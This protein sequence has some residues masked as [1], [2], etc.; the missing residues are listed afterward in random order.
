[1]QSIDPYYMTRIMMVVSDDL[2]TFVA[3]VTWW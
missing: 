3:K 1:L 2:D